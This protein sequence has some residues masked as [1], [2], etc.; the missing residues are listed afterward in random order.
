MTKTD[1]A[2]RIDVRSLTDDEIDT[3]TGAGLV[4]YGSLGTRINISPFSVQ[5]LLDPMW[6]LVGRTGH[7]PQ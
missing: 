3:V 6:D 2:V 5:S 7:L 4:G 1:Q